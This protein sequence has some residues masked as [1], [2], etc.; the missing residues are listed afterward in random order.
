SLLLL[1]LRCLYRDLKMENVMLNSIQTQIKI[2]DFGLSNVWSAENPLRTHCGSPEYAAPELFV[3]GRLYGSEVDLWSLGIILY[4]MILGQLPFVSSRC[5]YVSSQERRRQLVAKINKGLS[6]PHRKALAPFSPEFRHVLSRLLAAEASKRIT[7]KELL[8]HPWITDKGRRM[9]RTNP[10]KVLD[11]HWQAKIITEIGALLHAEPRAVMSSIARDPLGRAGGM[12]NILVHKHQISQLTGD[13]VTRTLP[14]LTILEHPDVHLAKSGTR[15]LLRVATARTALEKRPLTVAGN[16]RRID[17]YS[18]RMEVV[19]KKRVTSA[20]VKQQKVA[21]KSSAST[22][23]DSKHRPSTHVEKPPAGQDY[24][25]IKTCTLR[26][27]AYS[28]GI[29]PKTNR[30]ASP[31]TDKVKQQIPIMSN[32]VST[33]PVEA[34]RKTA[35]AAVGKNKGLMETLRNVKKLPQQ[36]SASAAVQRHNKDALTRV[37]TAEVEKAARVSQSTNTACGKRP[38]TMTGHRVVEKNLKHQNSNWPMQTRTVSK[39]AEVRPPGPSTRASSRQKRDNADALWARVPLMGFG[40]I[41][42]GP[43]PRLSQKNLRKN[44]ISDP[45]ARS[46]ADYVSNNAGQLYNFSWF[47]K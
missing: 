34:T 21:Q 15:Q 11:A 37:R 14:S 7:T 3:T 47:K 4:G 26:R 23:K 6:T 12:F 40:D 10:I 19:D 32:K 8:V 13:G 28:A 17:V 1:Q 16:Q 43:S 39:D 38:L 22:K 5:E 18:P 9:V 41:P 24:R 25:L 31:L 35:D 46:I 2:V 33:A 20:P 27:K 45:I 29:T 30:P 44:I 42:D 36:A